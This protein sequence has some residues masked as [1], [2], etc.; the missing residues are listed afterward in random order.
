MGIIFICIDLRQINTHHC[1]TLFELYIWRSTFV[2]KR[3]VTRQR[4]VGTFYERRIEN[5]TRIT[6]VQFIFNVSV[7]YTST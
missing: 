5:R 3:T 4:N 6:H 1:L 2:T 7:A